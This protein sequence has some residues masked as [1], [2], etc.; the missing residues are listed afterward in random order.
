[1]RWTVEKKNRLLREIRAGA[2]PTELSKKYGVPMRTL[3]VWTDEEHDR[4]IVRNTRAHNVRNW[5][6]VNVANWYVD[7]PEVTME[8][9]VTLLNRSSRQLL[10]YHMLHAD[11]FTDG[12]YMRLARITRLPIEKVKERRK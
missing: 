5:Q 10:R 4:I 2:K 3:A 11:C 8:M 9:L 12:D 6:L 1:M 7:H